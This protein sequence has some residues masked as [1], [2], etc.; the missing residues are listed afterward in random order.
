MEINFLEMDLIRIDSYN[1]ILSHLEHLKFKG[2][3]RFKITSNKVCFLTHNK[4]IIN[5][6]RI[7]ILF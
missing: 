4:L 3:I 5:L 2:L 7:Q 6:I 1:K